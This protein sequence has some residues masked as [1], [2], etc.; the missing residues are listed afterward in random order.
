MTYIRWMPFLIYSLI[1]STMLASCLTTPETPDMSE[2]VPT[3]SILMIQEGHND[4]TNLKV[5]TNSEFSLKAKVTPQ[6]DQSQ[7]EFVWMRDSKKLGTS[8]VIDLDSNDVIPN[9]LKVTDKEGNSLSVSFEVILNTPPQMEEKTIP[10]EGDTLYGNFF[11]AFRF[12]WASTDPDEDEVCSHFLQIDSTI[13]STT[14]LLEIQQ[15]G[16][17]PGSHEFRVW[18]VDSFGDADT[19]DWRSFTVVDTTGG[20]E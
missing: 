5:A 11:T 14:D 8:K 4:S 9:S 13:Y 16:L 1:V 20:N 18:V 19:L 15:A 12:S 7:L 17:S 6:S 2:S 3:L 10:S